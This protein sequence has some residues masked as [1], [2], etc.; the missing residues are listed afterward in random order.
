MLTTRT[1]S[2]GA[3]WRRS[4]T[5]ASVS[6]VGTSPQQAVTRVAADIDIDKS[7]RSGSALAGGNKVNP[8]YA[9]SPSASTISMVDCPGALDCSRASISE[10]S[11]ATT[12][13]KVDSDWYCVTINENAATSAVKAMADWVIAPKSIS[14]LMKAGATTKAGMI[15]MSQ[16]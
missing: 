13:A 12:A 6:I 7:F 14:P 10:L 11:R 8:S 4:S 2:S 1:F 5:A 3:C 9:T 16:L 15:W